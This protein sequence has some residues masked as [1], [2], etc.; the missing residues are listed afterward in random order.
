M[1]VSW[2]AGSFERK[3][4]TGGQMFEAAFHAAVIGKA[5]VAVTGH[6]IE[7]NASFAA[8]L[9]HAPD[10][11]RGMH[12]ADFTHPQDLEADLHL[13]DEV[14]LGTRDSYQLEKR[15]LRSD[16]AT[17]HVLLSATVVREED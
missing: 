14:M 5:I 7:V 8:M 9:G 15:Y 12:F 1:T 17:L 2:D 13:F 10:A 11:L 4:R 16:G 3:L 6:I